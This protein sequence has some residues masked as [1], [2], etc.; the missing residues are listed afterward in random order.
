MRE[1]VLVIG[2]RKFTRRD[3]IRMGVLKTQQAARRNQ[4]IRTSKVIQ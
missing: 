2:K 3:L 4:Y 1:I